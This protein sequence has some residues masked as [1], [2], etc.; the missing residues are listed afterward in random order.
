MLGFPYIASYLRGDQES[1]VHLFILKAWH[2]ASNL[3][4]LK[5]STFK[6]PL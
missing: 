3:V 6:G 4:K 5:Y 1:D 2:F